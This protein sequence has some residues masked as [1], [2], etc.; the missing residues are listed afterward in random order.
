MH[1]SGYYCEKCK[2]LQDAIACF[3]DRVYEV[4]DSVLL[5]KDAGKQAIKIADE[6]K[7]EIQHKTYNLRCKKDK[8][9]EEVTK[10]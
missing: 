5:R 3:G 2:G 10:L 1:W 4:V 8:V 7:K 9:K 6:I